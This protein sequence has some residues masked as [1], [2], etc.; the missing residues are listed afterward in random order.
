MHTDCFKSIVVALSIS[1]GTVHASENFVK[2]DIPVHKDDFDT[3]LG[4]W[5]VEQAPG[6]TV[7]VKDG[8]L[9]I[10]DQAGCTVWFKAKLSGPVVIEYETVMLSEGG[11]NNRV[12][13]L[14][15]FWMATDPKHPENIFQDETRGGMF[16]NYHPLRLYYVGYG[17]NKNTTTRFRRY[18][19][20][21]TRPCLPEHD[22][23]EK[24]FLHT[25]DKT[26][27]IRIVCE[28][29]RIRYQRNEETVF[30]FHDPEPLTKGWFGFRTVR[31]HMTIDNFRVYRLV[32][33]KSGD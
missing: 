12:S 10:D 29:S 26:L 22:L 19:G 18:A 4:Q 5:R 14:N 24:E 7:E 9:V 17:A 25:P 20:D 27:S 31:N 6:G 8:K 33:N 23:R 3:D 13:D 15:C 30:D 16:A 2:T 1:A 11:K 21:G 28:G 32:P